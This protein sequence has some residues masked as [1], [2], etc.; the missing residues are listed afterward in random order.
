M[1]QKDWHFC[2]GLTCRIALGTEP[3]SSN[4]RRLPQQADY[5]PLGEVSQNGVPSLNKVE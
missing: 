1:E 3:S 4:S 5:R 2:F